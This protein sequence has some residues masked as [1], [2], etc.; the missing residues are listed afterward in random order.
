[1]ICEMCTAALAQ[2]EAHDQVDCLAHAAKAIRER[3]ARLAEYE[4]RSAAREAEIARL[5]QCEHNLLDHISR[6][7]KETERLRKA[8]IEAN[9]R[10]CKFYVPHGWHEW[11]ASALPAPSGCEDTEKKT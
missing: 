8:L 4:T 6:A 9:A 1:M 5:E 11:F 2:N 10:V 7:D 3:D